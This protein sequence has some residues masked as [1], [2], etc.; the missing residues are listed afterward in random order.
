MPGV[1]K[2]DA[3]DGHDRW[4]NRPRRGVRHQCSVVPS[5]T[6]RPCR[7]G[8]SVERDGK[9]YCYQHD[10][11]RLKHLC[12]ATNVKVTRMVDGVPSSA[13]VGSIAVAVSTTRPEAR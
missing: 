7:Q 6:D 12:T 10:P 1:R 11:D 9:W 3:P 4:K 5:W 2:T 13:M 8:R